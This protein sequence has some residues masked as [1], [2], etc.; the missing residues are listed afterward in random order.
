MKDPEHWLYRFDA[1]EWL[2]A[3]ENELVRARAALRAKQQRP[4]L[5]GARRA[6]GMAWNAVLC[7]G[8]SLDESYG[9]SYMDHLKRIREDPAIPEQVRIA[10]D[11]LL[12]APLSPEVV[13]LGPGDTRLADAAQ[14]IVEH[15][16]D[17]VTPRASA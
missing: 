11:A 13:Q 6:A 16:R 14:T 1:G 4:G 9:R 15:A 8:P 12:G 10:A 5:A 7:T 3:A 17:R 2:R